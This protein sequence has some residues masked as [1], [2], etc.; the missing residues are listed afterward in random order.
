M[1]EIMKNELRIDEESLKYATDS[2]IKKLKEIAKSISG[3]SR[4]GA[5][6]VA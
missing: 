3:R 1:I 5:N 4:G 2:E 6:E